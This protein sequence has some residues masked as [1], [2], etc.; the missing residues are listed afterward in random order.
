MLGSIINFQNM[1]IGVL[2]LLVA[3]VGKNYL[4]PLLKVERS[5]RFARWI[6]LLADEITDELLARYPDNAWVKFID[7]AVDSLMEICGISEEIAS[8]AINSAL[9]RKGKQFAA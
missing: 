9:A 7:D 2:G 4:L 8:R 3:F 5:R 1:L 6:A